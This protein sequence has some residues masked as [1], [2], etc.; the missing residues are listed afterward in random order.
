MAVIER[1]NSSACQYV[2]Y[3]ITARPKSI[4][5]TACIGPHDLVTRKSQNDQPTFTLQ[6]VLKWGSGVAA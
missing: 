5:I 6:P 3:L 2:P 1:W 4:S